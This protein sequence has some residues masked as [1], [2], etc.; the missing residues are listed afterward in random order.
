MTNSELS[1]RNQEFIFHLTKLLSQSKSFNDEKTNS[2]IAELQEKLLTGQ[3]T[4]KTARQL[5]GTPTEYFQDLT[6]PK[7]A[8]ARRKKLA[9]QGHHQ[10][11][12]SSAAD[13]RRPKITQQLFEYSFW[14][15]F[16]DTAWTLLI[17]FSAMYALTAALGTSSKK[18]QGVGLVSLFVLSIVAGAVYVFAT[19]VLSPDPSKKE[20]RPVWQRILLL[21]LALAALFIVFTAATLLPAVI[22][23]A[24]SALWLFIIAIV[25]GVS[26]YFWRK[27]SCLP[28]GILIIGSLAT[29]ATLQYRQKYPKAKKA[30][31]KK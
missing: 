27:Q 1:K 14:T 19:R 10:A 31:S 18:V 7:A 23:P 9:Q 17:M 12:A 8:A 25:S 26:Y 30:R 15:E 5:F 28:K 2:T 6:D 11:A 29:N 21:L 4:G 24:L 16:L 3:K 22:N 13:A 20:R